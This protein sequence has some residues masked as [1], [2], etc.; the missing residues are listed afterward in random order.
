[1]QKASQTSKKSRILAVAL[2]VSL[3]AAMAISGGTLSY[4][5]DA[6]E[7]DVVNTFEPNYVDVDL[8]ETTGKDYNIIPGTSEKKDP[9]VTVKTTVDTYVFVTVKDTTGGLVTW[10]ADDGWNLFTSDEDN[11][12][13]VY[14]RVVEVTEDAEENEYIYNVLKGNTVS[15]SSTLKNEDMY[16][17]NGKPLDG[18]KLTFSAFAIQKDPFDSAASAYYS[19]TGGVISAEDISEGDATGAVKAVLD[20]ARE[21]GADSVVITFPEANGEED[22]EIKVSGL[23]RLQ[24]EGAITIYDLNGNTLKTDNSVNLKSGESLIITDGQINCGQIAIASD[25]VEFTLK[26]ATA[27]VEDI[28]VDKG[29]DKATINIE[30]STITPT[31]FYG[32]STNAA[33]VGSGKDVII[34]IVDSTIEVSTDD[35]DC[36][37][38]LFNIP[39]TLNIVNSTISGQRQGIIARCGTVNISDSTIKKTSSVKDKDIDGKVDYT[40]TKW[41]DGNRVV[42]AP[43]TIGN[44]Q[45]Q[46][47]NSYAQDAV[48][49]LSNVQIEKEEDDEIPLVYLGSNSDYAAKLVCNDNSVSEEQLG[50][51]GTNCY[52]NDTLLSNEDAG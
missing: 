24:E 26:N 21:A 5:S 33:T 29:V 42:A 17:E 13:S 9:T 7:T 40:T 48:V 39:G 45:T 10:E 51:S 46:G 15:Y 36:T 19:S 8:S 1:M 28:F 3:A 2:A 50:F 20:E 52:F 41:A 18:L 27:S 22:S 44:Y 11:G 34:N 32:V 4:L 6:T 14:Y 35:G 49:T 25:S 12:T 38:V 16:D 43:L 47:S 23:N 37:G 30:N 31:S